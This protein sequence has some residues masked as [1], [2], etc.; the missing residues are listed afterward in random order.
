[1]K[2]KAHKFIKYAGTSLVSTVFDLLFFDLFLSF[3][4]RIKLYPDVFY[5]TI[6]ARIISCTFDYF[7]NSKLVFKAKSSHKQFVRHILVMGLQMLL[8]ASLLTF[9]DGIFHGEEILEKCIIDV[10]L[11]FVAYAFQKHWVYKEN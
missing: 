2:E 8:S 3:F 5:A 7:L 9:V 4:E 10:V 1:M 6:C 11:F